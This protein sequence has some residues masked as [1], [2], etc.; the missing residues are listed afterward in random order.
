M[1]VLKT[2]SVIVLVSLLAFALLLYL[3]FGPRAESFVDI[4]AGTS[5]WRT[6]ALLQG[7]SIIRSSLAFDLLH[8]LHPRTLKAGEYRFDHPA[9][10]P[11]VY[12]RIARGDVYTR[13]VL[14]PEGFNIFDVAAAVE[15]AGLVPAPAFLDAARQDISL[16]R[17]LDPTARS[18]EGYLFPDTYRFS[19]HTAPDQ[20]IAAMVRRFRQKTATLSL[21][22]DTLILA[23]IVEKEVRDPAERP[24]VAGVFR[25][26]LALAMPLATDPT[27][28]YA[29]SALTG[30]AL[31][32]RPSFFAPISTRLR[33]TTPTVTRDC[34]RGLSATRVSRPWRRPCTRPRLVIFTS[35]PM[36][37]D[38]AVLPL[39]SVITIAMSSPS[40][41][42]L[43]PTFR[44]ASALGQKLAPYCKHC[45]SNRYD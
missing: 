44:R 19:R 18:L 43:P 26:R 6:A 27:V 4:P 2:L 28:I 36:P 15:Q 41:R 25:N 30:V 42:A 16:I 23:S 38:T 3:P 20:M 29:C 12:R 33:S 31:A 21:H 40:G 8:L 9:T 45:S 14:V 24:L 10:L 1:T 7:Q 22:P 5:S 13:V 32:R 17:D 39:V 35:L 11:E 34:H 37:L